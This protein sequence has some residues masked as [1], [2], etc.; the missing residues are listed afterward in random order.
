MEARIN[1]Y[2]INFDGFVD[3]TVVLS[4]FTPNQVRGTV[5]NIIPNASASVNMLFKAGNTHTYDSSMVRCNYANSSC[6]RAKALP[7]ISSIDNQ[8][9]Y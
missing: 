6:Y 8:Q 2:T 4:G 7:V 5:G 3:E 9:G 1:G